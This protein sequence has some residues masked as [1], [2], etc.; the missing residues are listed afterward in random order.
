MR[1]GAGVGAA[2]MDRRRGKGCITTVKKRGPVSAILVCEAQLA[3][4]CDYVALL[5]C[6]AHAGAI[7]K[8][9][10]APA[11][12]V[13]AASGVAGAGG[14][15]TAA[16]NGTGEASSAAAGRTGGAGGGGSAAPSAQEARRQMEEAMMK[17]LEKRAGQEA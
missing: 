8:A 3:C 7:F 4:V 6:A 13:Q 10:Q 17:V 12:T 16:S 1:R 11:D 5:S 14:S 15:G 9:A 2:R